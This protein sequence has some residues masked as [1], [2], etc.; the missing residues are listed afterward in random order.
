MS[1]SPL[2]FSE[3][4]KAAGEV[5]RAVKLAEPVNVP[6]RT[7][8]PAAG[9]NR[10]STLTP[11][12]VRFRAMTSPGM[13]SPCADPPYSEPQRMAT[14][15]CSVLLAGSGVMRTE[16]PLAAHFQNVARAASKWMS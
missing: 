8:Y 14:L 15:V 10:L 9:L 7:G 1:T 12:A 16:T 5:G 13:R 6:F 3:E 4:R 11:L 2:P